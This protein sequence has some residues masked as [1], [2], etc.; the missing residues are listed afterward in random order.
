MAMIK[1][2]GTMGFDLVRVEVGQVVG[3]KSDHEQY[4]KI[5]KIE[6][7]MLTLEN[8]NGFGGE[9]LRYATVTKER[10]SDCWID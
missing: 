10:A 6:G 1:K 9:Y 5:T 2:F 4:G 8:E 3:F 7:D